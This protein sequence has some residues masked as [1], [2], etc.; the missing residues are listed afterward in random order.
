VTTF[1]IRRALSGLPTLVGISVVAFL[2]LGLL[3]SDPSL[4]WSAGEAAPSAE[5][6]A[7][8]REAA[9]DAPGPVARYA[10]WS[11]GLLRGDLG[12]S[13]RDGRPVIEVIGESLLFTLALNLCAI[14]LLYGLALPFGLLGAARPV[15]MAD[16]IGR[17]TLLAL[18][19]V[20]SFAAALLL[21]EVFAVRLRL[22]PLQGVAGP[23][24]RAGL[25]A[26]I[27]RLR[28]LALPATCLALG[29]WAYV[30]RY[31]RAAC[32]DALGQGFLAA[33][34]ARGLSRRRALL[35]VAANAAIPLLTLLNA[36]IPG[37]AGGSVLVEHIFSWP[38]VGRLY[39]S[40]IE[41]RDAPV[42]LGLTLLSGTLV[43][44]AQVAVDLLYL[45]VEPRLRA[46]LIERTTD[47][48]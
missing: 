15:S 3:P 6:M 28:H 18:Y 4:T 33:A 29:G 11:L 48:V 10:A 31:A 13:I 17:W 19:A 47:V 42:L 21:Q 24:S 34:R 23:D 12:R 20:P 8:T 1:L 25:A 30:A 45:A 27:D 46:N 37:L 2:L 22:L 32:R 40:A 14:L 43:L 38:G 9:G 26:V 39:L 5:A 16:R 36:V 35:H 7:R 41:G 44:G